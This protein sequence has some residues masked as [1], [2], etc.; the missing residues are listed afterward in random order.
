MTQALVLAD[1]V[2]WPHWRPGNTDQYSPEVRAHTVRNTKRH[3]KG[4][5]CKCTGLMLARTN[6]LWWAALC[7][8][9]P[10]QQTRCKI[11]CNQSAWEKTGSLHRHEDSS[12]GQKSDFT[13]VNGFNTRCN[14][15][16][17]YIK[18]ELKMKW[19]LHSEINEPLV[20]FLKKVH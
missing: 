17:W 13:T 2:I 20:L 19:T 10:Q 4:F 16:L 8:F 15:T 14:E 9:R 11:T 3:Q 6:T 7:K 18:Y 1:P 5:N 12:A